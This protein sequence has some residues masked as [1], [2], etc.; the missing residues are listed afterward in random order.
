M[1]PTNMRI[2]EAEALRAAIE[3]IFIGLGSERREAELVADHLVEANLR[4]HDSHGVGMMPDYVCAARAGDLKLNRTLSVSQGPG[5]VLICDA[6]HGVGQVMAH[7][8]M[9]HGIDRV[10]RAG[11]A[12]VVLRNSSHIGRIGH[13]A[14][15]CAQA[16]LVSIHFVNVVA[17]PIVAPFG[18]THARLGTNPFAAGFP[19]G[20]ERPPIIVDFATSQLAMGKVRVAHNK[21]V[22]VPPGTLLDA[23]GEPTNDP[24][25]MFSDPRG[26]LLAFG[27][28]KGSALSLTCELLGA[29]LSGATV[30]SGPEPGLAVLNSMF[31]VIIDPAAAGGAATYLASQDAVADWFCSQNADGTTDIMLPGE[32]ELRTRAQRLQ[33]GIP[34]D[35]TTLAAVIGAA[36]DAGVDNLGL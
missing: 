29:A 24:A 9:E 22:Q 16:G 32:P 3:A 6:E 19:R 1:A 36:R 27:L 28:H 30:Q 15:Q 11:T 20:E 33:D 14:E 35:E 4:G 18:G 34:V 25:V 23:Q 2:I 21:Q 31:S 12:I 8:A 5:S 10:R 26:A 17:P 13:W 7:E